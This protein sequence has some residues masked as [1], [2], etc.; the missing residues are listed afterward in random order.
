M[1]TYELRVYVPV[2][3]RLDDLLARFR[4]HTDALF[5]EHGMTSQGYWL[6]AGGVLHYLLRHEGD[7]DANWSSFRADGRWIAARDASEADGPIV[8]SITATRLT[9]TDFSAA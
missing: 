9:P 8:E 2:P 4:D 1:P 6:D 5:R 3:G 7:P